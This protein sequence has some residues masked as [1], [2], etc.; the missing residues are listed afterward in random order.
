MFKKIKDISKARI[1]ISNDDG[2]NAPGIKILE[3]I[4]RSLT[5]DVWVIAPSD[6]QSAVAHSLTVRRPLRIIKKDDSHFAVDGTPTDSVLLAIRHVLKDHRPDLML[7][8][9]NSGGNL[10]EDVTYSGTVA[11]AMEATLLGIPA[12]AFSQ[13][14]TGDNEIK[15]SVASK[16][17]AEIIK[18]IIQVDWPHDVLM[19]VNF[20]DYPPEQIKGIHVTSQGKRQAPDPL[21]ER[22]DPHKKSYFWIGGVREEDSGTEGTDLAAN[23]F[24]A[25]SI[26]PLRI[27]FTA[28]DVIPHLRQIFDK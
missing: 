21:T 9:V 5:S 15:W 26:T 14:Y 24:G 22:K 7:S 2:I 4:A 17:G 8:G 25:I 6:E 28:K 19:N 27:D 20:P 12:I 18:K 1:L 11:A 3:M 13:K 16:W 10:G 23:H